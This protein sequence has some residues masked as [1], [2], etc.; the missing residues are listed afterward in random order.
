VA[1]F[2]AQCACRFFFFWFSPALLPPRLQSPSCLVLM[3]IFPSVLKQ[4]KVFHLFSDCVFLFLCHVID[5]D[6][7]I[8][9]DGDL[10]VHQIRECRRLQPVP[11]IL[12][13][14]RISE[15]PF[16]RSSHAMAYGRPWLLCSLC[17]P[18]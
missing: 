18:L 10:Y 7:K 15:E 9:G 11:T 16:R 5:G 12:L 6:N 14:R 1:E 13:F 4:G 17:L 2:L 8:N 3:V